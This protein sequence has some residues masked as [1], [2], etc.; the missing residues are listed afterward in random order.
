MLSISKE[1]FLKFYSHL[2]VSNYEDIFFRSPKD[3]KDIIVNM[4]PSKLWRLNNLY[5]IVNK[6]GKRVPFIMNTS[7]HKV[8]AYSLS[9][10]RLIILKSRQQGIS[11]LWLVSF[12]DDVCFLPDL[13]VGLQAQGK[14]EASTLLS[15]TKILWDTLSLEIKSLLGITKGKDSTTEIGLSNG[16]KIFIRTSFRSATLQRLHVSELGKIANKYPERAKEVKTG[17]LQAISPENTAIIESTAE[18]TNEFKSMWDTAYLFHGTRSLRDFFPVFLSWL[19]DPDCVELV[20]Q[21]E[22]TEDKKYFDTLEETLQISLTQEQKNFW[23]IKKRELGDEIFREYPATPEEA[24]MVT[25]EGTYYAKL[26]VTKVVK[27]QRVIKELYDRNLPVQ[28]AV[29]LGMNN[30]NVLSFFQ[31]YNEEYRI[32]DEYVNSGEDI[33][34]YVLKMSS[35][36]NIAHLILP[37]DARVRELTSGQTREERFRELGCNNITVLDRTSLLD[38]IELFRTVLKTKFFIDPKCSYLISCILN[39]TREWDDRYQ[40]WK[41]KPMKSTF[42]NGADSLR[43]V[44]QGADHSLTLYKK[45]AGVSQGKFAV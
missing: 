6:V 8:F 23:I 27:Q 34:H 31:I 19:Q 37:H 22:T 9:Y 38:G 17:T 1:Q 26:Y 33:E 18:G 5:T 7:Q 12:F 44:P 21:Y 41:D 13:S 30:E 43:Y 25:R 3:R 4:L 45:R 15:R 35:M 24:F 2:T 40:V 14:D 42:N 39:Y 29:D 36:Y 16:S 20:H 32:V 10:A 11:T 28:V